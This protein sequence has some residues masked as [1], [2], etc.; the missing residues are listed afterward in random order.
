MPPTTVKKRLGELLVEAGIIDEHQLRAAL[1]Q[2]RQWGGK[3]GRALV[4]MKLAS[5]AQIVEALSR[6]LGYATVDLDALARTPAVDAAMKLVPREVARQANIL[7]LQADVGSVTVAMSDPTN[8]QVTDELSF[9]TG[10]RVR[11]VLAGDQEVARAV[12]RLY[13]PEELAAPRAE[14]VVGGGG[15]LNRSYDL[16]ADH[17]QQRFF[18][19]TLRDPEAASAPPARTLTPTPVVPAPP[20]A[21]PTPAPVATRAPATVA[22]RAAGPAPTPAPVPPPAGGGRD[23]ALRDAIERLAAGEEAPSGLRAGRLAGALAIVLL[24]RGLVTEAEILA[25]LAKLRR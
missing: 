14:D 17:V 9:R 11:I 4:D 3:L 18:A 21:A 10:R 15:D 13:F 8:I 22:P 25:E 20:P 24:R 19:N 23:A 5:E 12:A 7:P 1:G 6:K 16:L 2:Q